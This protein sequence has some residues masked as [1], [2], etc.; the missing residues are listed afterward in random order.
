MYSIPFIKHKVSFLL[1][2]AKQSNVIQEN[3]LF[4][5]Y[6]VIDHQLT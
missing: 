6:L 1:I 2:T 3:D 4:E 5:K